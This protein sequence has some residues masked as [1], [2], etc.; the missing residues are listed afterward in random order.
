MSRTTR[1]ANEINVHL[2]E[3]EAIWLAISNLSHNVHRSVRIRVFSDSQSALR[4]IQSPKV[5]DSLELVLKIREKIRKATYSL[6]WFPGHEGIRDNERA[7]ELA[8]QATED[9]R[10]MKDPATEILISTIYAKAKSL[11]FARAQRV[12]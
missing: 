1:R 6:H 9:R 10:P 11:D 4:S 12:L 2:T 7:N 5:N 3:L 8:Q